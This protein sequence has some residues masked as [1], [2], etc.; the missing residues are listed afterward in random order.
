MTLK[1]RE[2]GDSAEF[3]EAVRPFLMEREAEHGL[4]L[5]LTATLARPG[6]S[7]TGRNHLALV[8]ADG[9]VVGAVLMT[10]PFGPVTSSISRQEISPRWSK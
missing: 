5:G 1:Y 9:A 8:E 3:A 2:Y 4:M 7:Y 10:P 6:S